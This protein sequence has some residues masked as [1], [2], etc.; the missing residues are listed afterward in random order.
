MTGGDTIGGGFALASASVERFRGKNSRGKNSGVRSCRS[1][2][3]REQ[4]LYPKIRDE[5]L[6]GKIFAKLR[7]S[8]APELLQ[9]LTPEFFPPNPT[10]ADFGGLRFFSRQLPRNP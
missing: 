5:H 6:L 7:D 8:L 9:L 4:G 10:F 3:I 2:R 1:C